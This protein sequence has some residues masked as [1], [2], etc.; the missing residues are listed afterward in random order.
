MDFWYVLVSIITDMQ[1]D[2]FMVYI[3]DIIG[4]GDDR[5]DQPSLQYYAQLFYSPIA[6][7]NWQVKF[8]VTKNIEFRIK[9]CLGS[10]D[11]LQI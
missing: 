10:F 4:R 7:N 8:A 1:V 2:Q 9:V 5:H 11:L 6:P 3:D